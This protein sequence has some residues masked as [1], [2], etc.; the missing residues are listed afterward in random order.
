MFLQKM[1]EHQKEIGWQQNYTYPSDGDK[2]PVHPKRLDNYLLDIDVIR[3][4]MLIYDIDG[5]NYGWK[6]WAS[7]NQ[8]DADQFFTANPNY[9]YKAV[10]QLG[11]PSVGPIKNQRPVYQHNLKLHP[12]NL[13]QDPGD[14]HEDDK[15]IDDPHDESDHAFYM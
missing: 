15:Y 13:G 11:Y 3:V 6:Q 1:N 9:S 4:I 2:T 12:T 7:H 5:E 8:V 14:D 10:Q